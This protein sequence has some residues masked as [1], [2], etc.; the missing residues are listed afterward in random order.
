MDIKLVLKTYKKEEVAYEHINFDDEEK[1][2]F[3][4]QGFLS[5]Y[6]KY[7]KSYARLFAYYNRELI[8]CIGL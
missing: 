6:S 4:M 3:F 7:R 2:R 8:V 5:A 1:L